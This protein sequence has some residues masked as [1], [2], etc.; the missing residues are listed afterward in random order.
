MKK[1]NGIKLH[2]KQ[3][4]CSSQSYPCH[5]NMPALLGYSPTGE[6]TKIR[7][8]KYIPFPNQT[9]YC[10]TSPICILK[11]KPHQLSTRT[12]PPLC[13]KKSYMSLIEPTIIY[14]R[15][16]QITVVFDS[17]AKHWC[18]TLNKVLLSGPDLM[19]S[20]QGVVVCFMRAAYMS[21]IE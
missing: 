2:K 17:S 19:N 9:V 7:N 16:M 14:K 6:M 4:K 8:Y 15:P 1:K 11:R 18:F 21:N 13:R 5:A 20:L 12:M 3:C 10:F